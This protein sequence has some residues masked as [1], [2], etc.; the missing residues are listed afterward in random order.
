[1]LGGIP[2]GFLPAL[3]GL[4]H[5]DLKV[6]FHHTVPREMSVG[7]AAVMMPNDQV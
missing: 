7:N 1:M 6:D 5:L 2:R 4:P 3:I